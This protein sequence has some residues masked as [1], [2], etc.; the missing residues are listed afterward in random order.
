MKVNLTHP[1]GYENGRE[2]LDDELLK[3][4]VLLHMQIQ[5][6]RAPEN[7]ENR[8]ERKGEKQADPIIGDTPGDI[9]EPGDTPL[10]NQL[11]T[12]KKRIST[13]VRNSVEK[14]VWL[15]LYHL[16][17]VF[18]LSPM[19][20]DIILV[21]LAPEVD[22]KYERLYAYLHGDAA[23]KPPSVNL[24]LDLL[25]K[26][27][28][29]RIDARTCFSP[30][31]PLFTH[32]LISFIDEHRERPLIARGVKPGDRVV[33]FLL[34]HPVPPPVSELPSLVKT[35]TPSR[36]W[37]AVLS[38][39]KRKDTLNRLTEEFFQTGNTPGFVFYSRGPR[40][41]GKKL[42]AEAFCHQHRLLLITVD[43]KVLLSAPSG[44]DAEKTVNRLFRETFLF[45]AVIYMENFDVLFTEEPKND[46]YR[47]IVAGAVEKYP[48]IVFLS[49]EKPW[50]S[51]PG[52]KP[53]TFLETVFPVPSYGTR[54]RMWEKV[55]NPGAGVE[56][57]GDTNINRLV[58]NLADK[59]RLTCGQ[60]RDA[61]AEARTM[62]VT[63]GKNKGRMGTD[64][65]YRACRAQSNN[66]LSEL[67]RKIVPVNGWEDIVLAPDKLAMLKEMCNHVK[68]RHRVYG[69]WG[70]GKKLSRGKGLNILFAGPSGT[71]KTMAAEI[72]AS[73]L[74][75]D[76]YK[77][78][79]SRVVSKYI[80]ETE[81][82]LSAIFKEAET[83][84]A[85]LFFDEADALFGKRSEVKD[86][87]DRYANIETGYLLQE[88][89]E[90][91]G[92]VI[93]A[94]NFRKN[95]DDAFTRRIHFFLDFPFPDEQNRRAIWRGIFPGEMPRQDIDYEFLGRGFKVSGGS[96]KNIAINTA[97]LAAGQGQAVS[98]THIAHAARREYQKEGK[99]C[100]PSDFGKYYGPAVRDSADGGGKNE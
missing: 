9:G 55:L 70:F 38:G 39:K 45:P 7:R 21:C 79:L 75:L 25:C 17:R 87:H 67:A 59:F 37:T 91:K 34:H 94:T 77:I 20:T 5:R 71:G 36:D 60:I 51:R 53:R 54:K 12:I 86:A 82:N 98:M 11:D 22:L 33:E 57:P 89:E 4:D 80:G 43:T 29:E 31:S 50:D 6:F 83:A 3:L 73:V 76:L 8:E 92:I 27:P 44:F 1:G 48:F 85:V 49:G 42:T 52:F 88:M 74:N 2:H 78:D 90:H 32:D 61:A 13:A 10:E 14:G 100:D 69:D 62:A 28:Q 30:H 84:N 64:E 81:K 95:I 15:P 23:Q 24:I 56:L 26:T 16:A 72:V 66:K 96:I 46:L 58:E 68:F 40:G 97:F 65:L 19:E 93:M 41:A 47:K 99:L 35:V 18:R 63:G